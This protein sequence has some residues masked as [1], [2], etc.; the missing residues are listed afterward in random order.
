MIELDKTPLKKEDFEKM[1]RVRFNDS[2]CPYTYGVDAV[3]LLGAVE[4]LKDEIYKIY[5][6]DPRF[7]L[8]KY[9]M[10]EKLMH[11][12]FRVLK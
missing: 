5:L 2:N 12:F 3:R 6:D 1:T 8:S 7:P 10:I 11:K 9:E 4:G